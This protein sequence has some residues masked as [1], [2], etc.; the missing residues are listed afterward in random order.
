MSAK[1]KNFEWRPTIKAQKL[2]ERLGIAV[3]SD[4]AMDFIQYYSKPNSNQLSKYLWVKSFE[5]ISSFSFCGR[6]L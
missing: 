5:I 2:R 3:S 6:Q 4:I 1:R